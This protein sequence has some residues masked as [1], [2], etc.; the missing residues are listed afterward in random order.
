M[1]LMRPESLKNSITMPYR[2]KKNRAKSQSVPP[3]TTR[4]ISYMSPL[5]N[6]LLKGL[7]EDLYVGGSLRCCV[8]V[9]GDLKAHLQCQKQEVRT[10][11]RANQKRPEPLEKSAEQDSARFRVMV[12]CS[13][14]FNR[15]LNLLPTHAA[16]ED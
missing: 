15:T 8:P 13:A 7:R 4:R 9:G 14:L 16:N 11:G 10:H 5:L 6:G 12:L 1:H 2:K 3:S